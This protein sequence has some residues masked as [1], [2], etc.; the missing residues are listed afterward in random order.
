VTP[1]NDEVWITLEDVG[2]VQVF[3]AK[4]PFAQK[5]GRS[6]IY[7]DSFGWAKL[8]KENA[9]VYIEETQ[10]RSCGGSPKGD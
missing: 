7:V 1:E 9:H 4:P 6:G 8:M 10:F 5:V 2:K 3:S